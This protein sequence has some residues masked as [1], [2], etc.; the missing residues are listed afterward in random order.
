MS[1][2]SASWAKRNPERIKEIKRRY[3]ERHRERIKVERAA[4]FQANK[5]KRYA[6]VQAWQ[7]ANPEMVKAQALR[8]RLRKMHRRL[9]SDMQLNY[10]VTAEQY[11]RLTEA[12]G[13]VCAICKKPNETT[14]TKRL[15][16]DH[17][18]TTGRLRALLCHACNAGLGYFREDPALFLRAIAYLKAFEGEPT[19]PT[20]DDDAIFQLGR[21]G[22]Q[23]FE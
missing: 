8:G 9:N 16:V 12:Q 10:N 19:H 17:D 23:D 6:A 4:S 15:F 7:D 18:H 21:A 3:R 14:R 11:Q 22:W 5:A 13:G 20:W 2:A 1:A